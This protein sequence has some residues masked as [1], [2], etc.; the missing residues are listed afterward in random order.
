[1]EVAQQQHPYFPCVPIMAQEFRELMKAFPVL[2]P[3]A[4]VYKSRWRLSGLTPVAAIELNIDFFFT[5]ISDATLNSAGCNTLNAYIMSRGGAVTV[6]DLTPNFTVCIGEAVVHRLVGNYLGKHVVPI[7]TRCLSTF[8]RDGEE[9]PGIPKHATQRSYIDR[10]VKVEE[11]EEEEK[12][13]MVI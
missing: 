13:D 6:T 10:N 2:S 11:D 4:P 12:D 7:V 9:T 5:E 3:V 1:M 8:V